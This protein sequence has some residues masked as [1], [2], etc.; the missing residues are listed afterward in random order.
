[1]TFREDKKKLVRLTFRRGD[2]GFT[3]TAEKES[4]RFQRTGVAVILLHLKL[5]QFGDLLMQVEQ[6]ENEIPRF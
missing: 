4:T 3:G 1:M 6:K 2:Q 5:A